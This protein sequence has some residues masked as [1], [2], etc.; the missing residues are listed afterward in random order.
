MNSRASYTESGTQSTYPWPEKRIRTGLHTYMHTSNIIR[1]TTPGTTGHSTSKGTTPTFKPVE[2]PNNGS[3][4]SLKRMQALQ[5][6]ENMT[7]NDMKEAT[8]TR[9]STLKPRKTFSATSGPNIRE[10]S[11][12][13][14]IEYSNLQK[15]TTKSTKFIS[16]SMINSMKT[17][18]L[19]I[20]G[21]RTYQ[22][23]NPKGQDH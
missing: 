19:R 14:M 9:Y 4:T 3:N 22:I 13:N 6:W 5:Q 18:Y 16:P 11:S 21:Q 2:I 20:G 17:F 8:G 23:H 1:N 10:T 15:H 7:L 12:C